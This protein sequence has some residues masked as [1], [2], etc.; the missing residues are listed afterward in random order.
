[1]EYL[2]Y[3]IP[4]VIFAVIGMGVGDAGGKKN[5]AIGFILGLALGPIG[6]IVAAVLPPAK[7][8][9]VAKAKESEK[10][11]IARL[12]LEL[13]KVKSQPPAATPKPKPSRDLADE[14]GI[15]TYKLD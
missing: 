6:C 14:G 2:L 4:A 15:P 5:G 7:D 3:L 10:E 9:E 12:E 11:R 8:S 1:M 13:A